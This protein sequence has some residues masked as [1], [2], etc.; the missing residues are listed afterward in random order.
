MVQKI[1]IFFRESYQELRKV[2]WPGRKEVMG[3]T[4][5]V[6]VTVLFCMVLTMLSDFLIQK[7]VGLFLK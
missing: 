3:S 2:T 1:Q 5:V 6:V 4:L 7:G